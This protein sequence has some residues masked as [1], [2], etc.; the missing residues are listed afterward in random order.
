LH[1]E[2]EAF[3]SRHAS[4]F[5]HFPAWYG[6]ELER[7]GDAGVHFLAVR[8]A[9]AA[10]IAVLPLEHRHYSL[11][12]LGMA[13]PIVQLYYPNEMGVNDVLSREPLRPHWAAISRF[14]RDEMPFSLLMRWQCVLEDG[15]AVTAAS[16]PSYVRST[17]QSKYLGF[18][19]G[20][21]AFVERYSPNF[22]ARLGKKMHRMGRLGEVRLRV[23]AEAS[24]LPA[25]FE[26]LLRVEDSGWKGAMGTSMLKQPRVLQ[27][28]R[29]LLDHFGR[30]GLCRVNLL[31]LDDIPVAGHFAIEVGAV[32]YLLKIGFRED[33]AQC[34]PGA[35]L[36]YKLV[37]H[38]CERGPVKAVS[39]VTDVDWIDRWHP[40]AVQAGVFYTD[41]DSAL[42]K[43]A[44]RMVRWLKRERP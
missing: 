30:L 17:H 29:H 44:V 28:Y 7:S 24:E 10:L 3:A 18:A 15:W 25:A 12:R 1:D 8:D 14:L 9:F 20:W 37:Q 31:F 4:H 38:C 26:H 34:S 5:V 16:S 41:C 42:S 40:S 35:V 33:H 21:Q 19:D 27:Y 36:L 6:A 43:V 2:W 39:F 13:V 32:L 22:R 11:R 23:Y